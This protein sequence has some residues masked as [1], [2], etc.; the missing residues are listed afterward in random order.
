MTGPAP[1]TPCTRN[2]LLQPQQLPEAEAASR[3]GGAATPLAGLLLR[4]R[5]VGDVRLDG[6]GPRPAASCSSYGTTSGCA[7]WSATTRS[8]ATASS[9]RS[10][11]TS[12][13][14]RASRSSL[15]SANSLRRAKIA[16]TRRGVGW[17]C[18]RN[19]RPL[20]SASTAAAANAAS[21]CG[22]ARK[23][24]RSQATAKKMCS[25]RIVSTCASGTLRRFSRPS[26]RVVTCSSRATARYCADSL[27]I[28]H[29]W[30]RR[31]SALGSSL[32]TACSRTGRAALSTRSGYRFEAD[33]ASPR[34]P[35]DV[36][37]AVPIPYLRDCECGLYDTA[38]HEHCSNKPKRRRVSTAARSGKALGH[39]KGDRAGRRQQH[40]QDNVERSR[41]RFER[42]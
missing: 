26:S 35:S 3:R 24:P 18:S 27:W 16:S 37:P 6:D 11:C 2:R 42:R 15:S 38:Q 29:K 31:L 34:G 41:T 28:A 14:A 5:L 22:W 1:R 8:S 21:W 40:G 7:S 36:P 10:N 23:L 17:A 30:M 39:E 13:W 20:V 25:L 32:H 33:A 19:S 9:P 12:R 4:S